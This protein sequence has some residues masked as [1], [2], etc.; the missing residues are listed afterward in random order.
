[1]GWC[2]GVG[3]CGGDFGE[4]DRWGVRGGGGRGEGS[5]GGGRGY[6]GG[7]RG[8]ANI[9]NSDRRRRFTHAGRFGATTGGEPRERKE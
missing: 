6:W 7:E 3:G 4:G 2:M 1:M 8:A 5:G 9:M